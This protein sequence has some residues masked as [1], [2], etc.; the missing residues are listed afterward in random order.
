MQLQKK[1][2]LHELLAV[3]YRS[4]TQNLALKYFYVKSL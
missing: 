4:S 2:I 1:K 3:M